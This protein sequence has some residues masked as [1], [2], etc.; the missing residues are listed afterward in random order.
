VS[1]GSKP[2]RRNAN[3]QRQRRANA[4]IP[5]SFASFRHDAKSQR[6][7]IAHDPEISGRPSPGFA[8]CPRASSGGRSS[9]RSIFTWTQ[10]RS[11]PR[12]LGRTAGSS[13]RKGCRSSR[14][15]VIWHRFSVPDV[16]ARH[17]SL[18]GQALCQVEVSGDVT[19]MR[20]GQ[21]VIQRPERV[22]RRQGFYVEYVE[23]R[24]SDAAF[25]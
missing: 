7:Q 5:L 9:T 19:D 17:S 8:R 3:R 20:R 2:S 18:G 15:N 24:A 23:R 1:A 22:I 6:R 4:T 25:T 10:G 14:S 16:H 21:D 13:I 11:S 12:F